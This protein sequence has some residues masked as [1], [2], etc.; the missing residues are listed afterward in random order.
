MKPYPRISVAIPVYN[1]EAV[2]SE[3]LRRVCAVLDSMPGEQAHEVVF[4]D[5]GSTD[6]TSQLLANAAAGDSRIRVV[7]LSRNFGH[8]AAL[9]AALDHVSGDAIVLLDGDLQ[10]PPEMI[11]TF[12]AAYIDGYDV[13]Y[14]QRVHRKERWFLRL[15]YFLFY[16]VIARLS[17]VG[18]P[19]DAGDF[20]LLSRQ[21]VD[22]IRSIPEHNRYLRGLRTWV[23]FRQLGIPVERAARYA[24]QPKYDAFKLMGLAL[25]GIL[26]FSKVPLRAAAVLG[27][28]TIAGSG[29]FAMYALYVKFVVGSPQGFTAILLA[30]TFLSGIQLVFL[31]IIGE[32]LGR[33]YEEA[34]GR[35]QYVVRRIVVGPAG[36]GS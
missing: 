24:G 13:V 32:Y 15:C 20:A 12:V 10:D 25:D 1:E 5:D 27:L 33:V 14:A 7:S 3:L 23:G 8:Q 21:V 11:P 34:K 6:G 17:D 9:S 26:A 18:L 22:G 2:L 29:M 30:I 4:V 35:P 31:G 28:L 19:L 16:R 36:H